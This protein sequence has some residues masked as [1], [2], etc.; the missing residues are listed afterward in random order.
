MKCAIKSP[1]YTVR[2][3]LFLSV[4]IVSFQIIIYHRKSFSISTINYTIVGRLTSTFQF[5][6]SL[7]TSAHTHPHAMRPYG[8]W[9]S[10]RMNFA[11]GRHIFFSHKCDDVYGDEK[12]KILHLVFFQFGLGSCEQGI[13]VKI[14]FCQNRVQFVNSCHLR[15]NRSDSCVQKSALRLRFSTN[16]ISHSF[17]FLHET[18][19]TS[20]TY[21]DRENRKFVDRIEYNHGNLKCIFPLQTIR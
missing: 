19:C 17:T 2:R 9:N 8:M 16:F 10:V 5:D 3:C 12:S 1:I 11:E 21:C 7:D 18:I 20:R 15:V 6:I 13:C 14:L 4:L